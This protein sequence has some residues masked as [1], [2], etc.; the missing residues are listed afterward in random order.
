M[1]FHFLRLHLAWSEFV[2]GTGL[3]HNLQITVSRPVSDFRHSHHVHVTEW[4][5]LL[6]T[7]SS[8]CLVVGIFITLNSDFT[9]VSV[10]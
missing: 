5:L 7:S 6:S 1:S 2:I 9:S 10:T 4:A 8:F 3:L